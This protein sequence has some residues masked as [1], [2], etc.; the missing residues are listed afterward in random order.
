MVGALG[1]AA[2]ASEP[3]TPL[4]RLE[5]ALERIEQM[6]LESGGEKHLS[7]LQEL[8]GD[9]LDLAERELLADGTASE[10]SECAKSR[11][12]GLLVRSYEIAGLS[13]GSTA[14]TLD[15]QRR[16]LEQAWT[17]L[18]DLGRTEDDFAVLILR[19]LA[20]TSRL[21]RDLPASAAFLRK[22]IEIQELAQIRAWSELEATWAS[23]AQ[24]Q[25]KL[26]NEAEAARAEARAEL[27]RRLLD[28]AEKSWN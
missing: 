28:D 22:A 16:F 9:T 26:G 5:T 25:R 1:S 21:Q 24:I 23:L 20:V 4:D 8:V 12:V 6:Q 27:L 3:E 14:E 2:G 15:L 17:F 13:A 19:N 10:L 11:A 18:E 7:E